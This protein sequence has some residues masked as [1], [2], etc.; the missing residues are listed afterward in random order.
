MPAGARLVRLDVAAPGGRAWDATVAI[1]GDVVIEA[2][3][4]RQI[5]R[6]LPFEGIDVG[7]DRRSPVSWELYQRKGTY[8]YTGKLIAVTYTPGEMA[9][10][11]LEA[12]VEELR[13]IG[14]KL[15]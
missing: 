1:D 14:L 9:P 3:G 6:F 10:D 8:P 7:I 11:A 4:L 5:W 2:P 12:R 15:E 13:E